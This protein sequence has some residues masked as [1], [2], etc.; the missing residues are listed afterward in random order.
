MSQAELLKRISDKLHKQ[1]A[2]GGMTRRKT[3]EGE[4]ILKCPIVNGEGDLDALAFDL[5]HI[6]VDYIEEIGL[7]QIKTIIKDMLV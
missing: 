6:F 1:I 2:F 7:K 5:T 4:I 3:I